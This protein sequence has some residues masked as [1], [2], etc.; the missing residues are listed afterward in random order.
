MTRALGSYALLVAV[1]WA[2]VAYGATRAHGAELADC[3]GGCARAVVRELSVPARRPYSR[4][5]LT[6]FSYTQPIIPP[7]EYDYE[8]AQYKVTRIESAAELPSNCQ[9]PLPGNV[10]LAC[11]DIYAKPCHIYILNDEELK[12]LGWNF[13]LVLRHEWAHCGGWP[14]NHPGIEKP[15][16]P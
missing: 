6:E 8:P 10:V 16:K 13:E 3:K 5:N 12:R 7:I 2:L 11:A 14:A 15:E 4:E 1:A 9:K